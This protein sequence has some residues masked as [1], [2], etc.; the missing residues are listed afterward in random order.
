MNYRELTPSAYQ[1]L[2]VA[3]LKQFESFE[4]LPYRDDSPRQLPTIGYGVRIDLERP[5]YED[6]VD[7]SNLHYALQVMGVDSNS[8]LY[9]EFFEALALSI[10]DDTGTLDSNIE[11]VWDFYSDLH[12]GRD[13]FSLS[14][15]EAEELLWLIAQDPHEETVDRLAPGLPLS[16]EKAALLSMTYQGA[17]GNPATSLRQNGLNN[18][19]GYLGRAISWYEIG[20]NIG[21]FGQR[22][23]TES[24]TFGLYDQTDGAADLDE[25]AAIARFINSK[26][27]FEVSDANINQRLSANVLGDANANIQEINAAL[28]FGPSINPLNRPIVPLWSLAAITNVAFDLGAGVDANG[29]NW[30][31]DRLKALV[32]WQ[33]AIQSDIHFATLAA[34]TGQPL[35]LKAIDLFKADA[36]VSVDVVVADNAEDADSAGDTISPENTN[37]NTI[38]LGS[39]D[40]DTITTGAAGTNSVVLGMEGNDTITG[41]GNASTGS[42]DLIDGGSGNDSIFGGG[43]IDTMFGGTGED[44]IDGKTGNDLVIGGIG[45][46]TIKGDEA[47]DTLFANTGADKIEGGLGDDSIIGDAGADW[48][49]YTAGNDVIRAGSGDDYI[50]L[51]PA[52]SAFSEWEKL[53]LVVAEGFGHDQIAG[54]A[55]IIKTVV[56][57]GINSTDVELVWDWTSQTINGQVFMIGDAMIR[58]KSTGDTLYLGSTS[59]SYR[60]G[61]FGYDFP[62]LSSP[63]SMVFADRTVSQGG[64]MSFFGFPWT[65]PQQ[66]VPVEVRQAM[67]T[68]ELEKQ[69]PDDGQGADTDDTYNGD[70]GDNDYNPGNGNDSVSGG[71]GNDS[72]NGSGY[73]NDGYDGGTGID[74]LSFAS[75]SRGIDIDLVSGTATGIEINTDTVTNFEVVVGGKGADSL[76][77]GIVAEVLSGGDGNDLVDGRDGADTIS[78][79]AGNDTLFGGAGTDTAQF[80]GSF[81][82]YS[83]ALA[84]GVLTVTSVAEGID[85]LSSDIETLSFSDG[86]YTWA[87]IAALLS[88]VDGT[89]GDDLINLS[90]VDADGDSSKNVATPG[91][92][93]FGNDGNDT[94]FG[95]AGDDS[96]FGGQG[97]DSLDGGVGN[98]SMVG[99]AGNDTYV[100]DVTTDLIG[101]VAGG[102][103]D[104]VQSLVTFTLAAELENLTLLG[105]AVIGGTGNEVANTLT[106]NSAAN[107]F[108]GLA[109]DDTLIGQAGN[110][111]LFGGD[112]NDSLDGGTGTDSL[113]GGAGN[114]TYVI[115]VTTDVIVEAPGAGTD[116]VQSFLTFTLATDLENLTLLGTAVLNGTGNAGANSLTGNAAANSLSGLAGNDTLLGLAGN[117]TLLGADGDDSLDGGVGTDSLVGGVGNDTYI[118]DATADIIVEAAG[119]GTDTVLSSV[120]RTLGL[121]QENLTLT[122]SAT[123]SGTGNAVTNILAGNIAANTLL[124]LDGNDSLFGGD[125]ND[126][127]DGGIGT[128]SLIGGLG[129]DTFVVDVVADVVVEASNE[130]VDTVQSSVTWTLGSTIENLTLLG[131]T[132]INGT[133]N[134]FGNN[135]TGNSAANSLS[136]LV[137]NDTLIGLGGNDT[138]FGGDGDDRLD[139]GVGTDSLVGGTGNDFYFV[140]VAT[141]VIVEAANGGIDTVQTDLQWTLGAEI[142]NVMQFGNGNRSVTGNGLANQLTGNNGNN[143]MSGL[144]GNDTLTGGAGNDNI[145]GGN[146]AD[147]FVFNSTVSGV[148]VIADFNELNGGGEEGDVFRFEGLR[149]GTFAY[150]GAGAFS[151][152]SDNSEARIT[153]NQLLYDAN[154]DGVADIT[155]TVT[156]LTSAGQLAMTDFVFI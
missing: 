153:G 63:F 104:T 147:H 38:L 68:H 10:I 32:N 43:G 131:T 49:I 140:D 151:G 93:I 112:G 39:E 72:F 28:G 7:D 23:L 118:V 50:D 76:R 8:A 73:G 70:D 20:Y 127:L 87:Q 66:N 100:V 119:G 65:I 1:D 90:F 146:G 116:T 40:N 94:I 12:V 84:N 108:T 60:L 156:G 53:T 3:M 115:D 129:N 155:I 27:G 145:T 85:T 17:F 58:V 26:S 54:N 92:R 86:S 55:G 24:E 35:T 103:V 51:T 154:G 71:G 96:L 144:D 45:H 69:T 149:V 111:T 81:A 138:L 113:V 57:E 120:T 44:E 36:T 25:A 22:R 135:L 29:S 15:E 83:F 2:V 98:D 141:D 130:G 99:G 133:G 48:I 80:A 122:G 6:G 64:Y 11:S 150:L 125:G 37:N 105:T 139:G 78:G 41:G 79:G 9:G 47:N 33:L 88:T 143:V 74:T 34:A 82:S 126:T 16:Y 114:D 14:E 59:G 107:S 18:E 95:Y 4:A 148:D 152:G 101:E 106:G 132:A 61:P 102:G 117:D 30:S 67:Q 75:T 128:D 13:D 5:G 123:I 134:T 137:G 42:D 52:Q 46:D 56:F 97:N 121:D 110:D 31:A 109:G 77:G 91:D 124:G 89:A 21:N 62:N 142:E 19:D 136:G